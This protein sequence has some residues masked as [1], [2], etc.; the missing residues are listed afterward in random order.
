MSMWLT[1]NSTIS[2]IH[3][4]ASQEATLIYQVTWLLV[5]KLG[6]DVQRCQVALK[7]MGG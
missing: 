2:R 3:D 6:R 4:K 5:A 7:E 1:L